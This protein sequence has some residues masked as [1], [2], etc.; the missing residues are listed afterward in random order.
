M[1]VKRWCQNCDKKVKAIKEY[2]EVTDENVY[3]CPDCGTQLEEEDFDFDELDFDTDEIA[4][5]L[6][7]D[8]DDAIDLIH[9]ANDYLNQEEDEE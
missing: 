5:I 2:D 8:E 4:E 6:G 9:D 1:S 3:S 7:I